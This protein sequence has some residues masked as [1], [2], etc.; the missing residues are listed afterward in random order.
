MLRLPGADAMPECACAVS[1]ILVLL[2]TLLMLLH[3]ASGLT[4]GSVRGPGRLRSFMEHSH[5]QTCVW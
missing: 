3:D 2:H 1:H 4:S 5:S